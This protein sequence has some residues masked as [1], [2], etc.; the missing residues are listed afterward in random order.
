MRV[1]T[2][3][4]AT[5]LIA[6]AL[7]T[8]ALSAGAAPTPA[9]AAEAEGFCPG[10]DYCYNASGCQACKPISCSITGDCPDP[11]SSGSKCLVCADGN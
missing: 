8:V 7:F 11:G 2:V 6:V 5:F 4:S 9:A 1:P 3:A 10:T